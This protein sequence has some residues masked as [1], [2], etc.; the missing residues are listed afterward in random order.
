VLNGFAGDDT[1]VGGAGNDTLNG[2][3]GNDAL[4]GG[5]GNDSYGVIGL[6][7]V[8]E[9]AGEGTDS[10][11]TTNS[12]YTLG[13]NLENL[14]FSGT[15]AF[16]GTG[17]ELANTITGGARND[18]LNGLAGNDVLNGEL[19][20]D[21]LVGG[22]GN[23]TL[24]GR[25]G[26][27]TMAGGAGNDS[28]GV[29]GQDVVSELAG[30]GTDSVFTTNANYTLGA[31]LENLVFSGAGA[32]TGSGNGLANAITGGTGSDVLNGF[33]G[34]DTLVGGAGN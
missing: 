32:F 22:A 31:N 8:S 34:D 18:T 1:L 2:G 14:V 4:A 10:V 15:S 6:D 9:L 29:I 25:A 11:F 21:T 17:N 26:N 20:N 12:S 7:V 33:A 13:A 28:Y 30:E 24:N 23:D 16:S 3:A 5:A 19:G 27:D